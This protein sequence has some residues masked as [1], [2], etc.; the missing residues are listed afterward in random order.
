MR[1]LCLPLGGAVAR[2]APVAS[3]AS[4]EL[5]RVDVGC[6]G[7]AVLFLW[8]VH[9]Y[10]TDTD[11]INASVVAPTPFSIVTGLLCL[12]T[13]RGYKEGEQSNRGLRKRPFSNLPEFFNN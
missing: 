12:L 6:A 3:A 10:V 2:T 11:L 1:L 5:G 13:N 7:G 4:R 8:Q 9:L